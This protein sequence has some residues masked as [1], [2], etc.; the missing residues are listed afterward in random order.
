LI[1]SFIVLISFL[2]K[3]NFILSTIIF[4]TTISSSWWSA[5]FRSPTSSR[6][7]LAW[8]WWSIFRISFSFD[9]F[10]YV[11]L[12]IIFM[13][14]LRSKIFI[15]ISILL[16][17][18]IEIR[19]ILVFRIFNMW[20]TFYLIIIF[21]HSLFLLFSLYSYCSISKHLMTFIIHFFNLC[22]HA[23]IR[24]FSKKRMI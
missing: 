23:I 12:F 17:V 5:S 11:M 16:T 8:T 21:S 9:L 20:F 1:L 4:F 15:I 10:V 13:I 6:T 24:F 2:L 3:V 19:L 7:D 18:F 22:P 14:I